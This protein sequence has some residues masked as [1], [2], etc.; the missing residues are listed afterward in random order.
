MKSYK[1]WK[2]PQSWIKVFLTGL[3]NI[4]LGPTSV[5]ECIEIK[6]YNHLFIQLNEEQHLE[7]H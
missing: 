4:R 7:L 6:I 1:I 2:R 5:V 3:L